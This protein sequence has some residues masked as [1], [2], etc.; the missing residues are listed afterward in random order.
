MSGF[1]GIGAAGS[2]AWASGRSASA[3]SMAPRLTQAL[4]TGVGRIGP[5]MVRRAD[6]TSRALGWLCALAVRALAWTWRVEREPWPVVGPSV[7]AFWHS[8]L[9]PMVALHRGRART[10][11]AA[12]VGMASR[13]ADGEIVAAA[14]RA[15]GY[16]VVRGSSSRGGVGA[17]RASLGALA[18]GGSPALA[19]DGPR[20]PAG[21]AQAGAAALARRAGV[22]LVY[23]RADAKGWRA[24]SWDRTLVPW[25]FARVRLTYGVLRDGEELG[26]RLG[27]TPRAAADR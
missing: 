12:L 11:G 13:S 18:E 26:E 15:L 6:F 22:P 8:E 27:P 5:R 25:P 20:G 10:G 24:G 4:A 16:G 21:V 9:V 23:G 1:S 3:S 7:V 14:L 2:A 19:V 17:L